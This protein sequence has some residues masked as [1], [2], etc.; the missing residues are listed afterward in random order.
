MSEDIIRFNTTTNPEDRQELDKLWAKLDEVKKSGVL[1]YSWWKHP[2]YNRGNSTFITRIDDQFY[3]ANYYS[4]EFEG[5]DEKGE[6][7]LQ[8]KRKLTLVPLKKWSERAIRRQIEKAYSNRLKEKKRI[9]NENRSFDKFKFQ[10]EILAP[11]KEKHKETQI[12]VQL[13]HSKEE[14]DA[15]SSFNKRYDETIKKHKR[16]LEQDACEKFG[17]IFSDPEGKCQFDL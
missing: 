2:Y 16:K 13:E 10:R 12:E 14:L 1:L 17:G 9:I 3:E 15:L 7:K 5:H 6:P 4:H 8:Y 11:L